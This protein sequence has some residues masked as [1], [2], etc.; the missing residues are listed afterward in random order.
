[1]ASCAAISSM[2]WQKS[3]IQAV[4][5]ACSRY[6]PV[7]SGALRS[8][9]PMLSSPRKPPSKTLLPERSFRFTHQVKLSVSLWK[10]RSS[11]SRSP[12]P[13]RAFS[14][15]CVKIVAH[16]CTGG[17]T[18]PKFHSYAGIWPLGWR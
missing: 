14:S 9:T 10:R 4:P 1:M 7:G 11:H 2:F 12:W 18:S 16:A 6:P 3:A 13:R 5:S 17:L 8:K 15:R